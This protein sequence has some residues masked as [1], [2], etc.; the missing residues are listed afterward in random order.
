MKRCSIYNNFF[1]RIISLFLIVFLS[2]SLVSCNN[3]TEEVEEVVFDVDVV[4]PVYENIEIT[5]DFIGQVEADSQVM[6]I[7]KVAGDVT[8]VFFEVGDHVN[9]GDLLFTVDDA[10]L[11]IQLAQ[12]QASLDSAKAAVDTA[13][14]NVELNEKNIEYTQAQINQ[15]TGTQDA[16][17][18]QLVNQVSAAK[19]AVDAANGNAKV[20]AEQFRLTKKSIDEL[21]DKIDDLKDAE[22][23]AEDYVDFLEGVK[24]TAQSA[25]QKIKLMSLDEAIAFVSGQGIVVEEKDTLESLERKYVSWFISRNTSGA[26]NSILELNTIIKTAEGNVSTLSG[27]IDSLENSKENAQLTRL[28]ASLA[29]D[30]ANNNVSSA[31]A[32]KK[33]AERMLADYDS[34]TKATVI[35][36]AVYQQ[37]AANTQLISAQSGV[38]QANSGVRQAQAGVSA[39]LLQLD[40]TRVKSPVSGVITQKNVTLNNMVSQ[41]GPAF[42]IN[43]DNENAVSFNVAETVMRTVNVGDNVLIER[44]G[45]KYNGV[46]TENAG[47][48]DQAS[49]L[50]KIKARI[51]GEDGNNLIAGTT[52]KLSLVTRKA[53]NAMVLPVDCVYY[54]NHTPYVFTEKNGA[55]QKTIVET[56]LADDKYI[57]IIS[58]LDDASKVITTWH[59]QLVDGSKVNSTLTNIQKVDE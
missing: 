5:G 42:V 52:V 34:F 25:G 16:N 54:E 7:P 57:E 55:A 18:L 44:N 49:G 59:S 12:A 38:I 1:M 50:F 27:Q 58:G 30:S 3:T 56:G 11:Q 22:D 48:P 4:N 9:A 35:A 14:A 21:D 19:Y 41:Q 23:N 39:A 43:S 53:E 13:N 47:F 33:L 26:A 31:E 37:A 28:Q 20:A 17:R 36:G 29:K 24:S 40:Y 46:V 10:G 32:Q 45:N 2:L 15:N 51:E 6:I 8:G